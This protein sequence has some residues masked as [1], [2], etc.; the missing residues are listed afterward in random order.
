[1]TLGLPLTGSVALSQ[2]ASRSYSETFGQSLGYTRSE[3]RVREAVI[4]PQELMGLPL[5]EMIYVE[6][7][8]G[9]DREMWNVDCHPEVGRSLRP[10]PILGA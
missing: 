10:A 2:S 8:P 1:L 5:T 4:E 9:G 7:L 6:V 3:H